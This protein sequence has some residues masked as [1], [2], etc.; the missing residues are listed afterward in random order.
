MGPLKHTGRS[1]KRSPQQT[2]TAVLHAWLMPVATVLAIVSA[3]GWARAQE[4]EED[5]EVDPAAQPGI[6][7]VR[8]ALVT[9]QQFDQQIFGRFESIEAYRARLNQIQSARLRQL[10]RQ[11]HLTDAQE[12]KL[13]LA[14]RGDIKRALD[15]VEELRRKFEEAKYERTAVIE[16]LQEARRL[17]TDLAAVTAGVN[18][19]LSKTIATTITEDQKARADDRVREYVSSSMESAAIEAAARL[20]PVLDLSPAQHRRLERLLTSEIRPPRRLG[21]STYAYVMYQLSRL[22]EADVRPIFRDSQ[23]KFLHELLM[24][25]NK[26]EK[27]LEND[28][29]VLDESPAERRRW[30]PAPLVERRGQTGE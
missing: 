27:F 23:W 16:C 13:F 7:F 21:G 19:L 17:R 22:P 11:Y 25:W 10:D 20:V 18:S 28:G 12:E 3:S 8:R 9:D 2:A 5:V 14:G 30:R 15:R 6:Q 24:S 4:D 29:F 26:A 1:G